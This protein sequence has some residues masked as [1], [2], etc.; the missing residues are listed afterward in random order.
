[1]IAVGPIKLVMAIALGALL[2]G[3][4]T[5]GLQKTGEGI[6]KLDA[7][8][9][10]SPSDLYVALASEYYRIGKMDAALDRARRALAIDDKSG[11]AHY[12]MAIV[13]QQLGE[14]DA[15][16]KHFKQALE[17][18]PNNGDIRNA[19]AVFLCSQGRYSE[20]DTQFQQALD[21]PLF[22]SPALALT[23]A[24]LCA[25]GAND[26]GKG[27][28]YLQRA[29]TRDANFAP[30]LYRLAEMHYQRGEYQAAQGYLKRLLEQ[31]QV[32]PQ[33][34]LLGVRVEKALG[35]RKQAKTYEQYLR[36]SF[37]NVSETLLRSL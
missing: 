17:L 33:P 34:L 32:T 8:E 29:L 10:D 25:L 35:N 7:Q 16:E 12:V 18:E 21:N 6:G 5:S 13:L 36:Q 26:Q 24:G 28:R 19:W 1:M 31:P 3:C 27:E 30:A 20:A 4:A 9:A 23:N 14:S 22:A 37:P 11:R 15:A 2:G